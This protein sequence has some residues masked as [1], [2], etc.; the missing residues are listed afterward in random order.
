MPSGRC[1][2]PP[3]SWP[4]TLGGTSTPGNWPGPC[5]HSSTGAGTGTTWPPPAGPR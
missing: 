3:S 1:C 4:P 2:W 5:G